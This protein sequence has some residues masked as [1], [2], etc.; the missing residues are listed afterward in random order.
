MDTSQAINRLHTG[1]EAGNAT[2]MAIP[3]KGNCFEPAKI[4][5]HHSRFATKKWKKQLAAARLREVRYLSAAMYDALDAVDIERATGLIQG[6]R[7]LV[8]EAQQLLERE[9]S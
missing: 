5:A 8:I 2:A 1:E 9:L 6:I 4:I 3:A 7:Y